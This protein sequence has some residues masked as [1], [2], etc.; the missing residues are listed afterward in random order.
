MAAQA[1]DLADA[2]GED[3]RQLVVFALG[4]ERLALPMSAVREIV[5]PL[6]LVPVPRAPELLLGL[7]NLR[8][9][10]LPVLDL[11][12]LVGAAPR[13]P[14]EATRVLVLEWRGSRLGLVV[15]AVH[16]VLE[17]A[18]DALETARGAAAALATG[19]LAGVV[20]DGAEVVQVLDLDAL[21]D[22]R[23]EAVAAGA[24]E[25][26]VLEAA[27]GAE[28][29]ADGGG[30]SG[31]DDGSEQLVAFRVGG[32]E[33]ALRIGEVREIVRLP[34]RVEAVPGAGP[35]A[36]G[37]MPLRG[38]TLPLVSLAALLGIEAAP[39]AAGARV[40]VTALP[41]GGRR[42]AVGLV[43]DAVRE[44]LRVPE[45]AREAVPA[46]LARGGGLGEIGELCRLE[47]GRR[48][49][50][51][52]EAG[53]L[54]ALEALGEVAEANA[55]EA[56]MDPESMHAETEGDAEDEVQLVVFQ[57]DGEEYG[58]PVEAV[59]EITRVPERLSRVP[60]TPEWVEGLVNLRGSALPVLDMR[61]RFGLPRAARSERQRIL[62]LDL[63]GTRTGFVTDSV[64]EVLSVPRAL[65]EAAPRLSE[66]QARLMGRVVNLAEGGRM[67]VVLDPEALV[68]ED[69]REALAESARSAA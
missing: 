44:V 16:R 36:L 64:T 6:P 28:T 2:P 52:L 34:E 33:L 17:A 22:G 20:R 57:L 19:V 56:D 30:A 14:D 12:R 62:V 11:R 51:V 10:V 32:Q 53:R 26:P 15:D 66:E 67:I 31:E 4:E 29:G 39:P 37:L 27:E 55:E 45:A 9:R 61:A 47:G 25:G 8:G 43:V 3:G 7:A 46:L 38:R 49:V 48:L 1:P 68:D 5:R 18:A 60:R 23:L 50:A 63:A 13:E 65:V 58:L 54:G 24:G 40:L 69:E 41:V 59:R 35:H 21:L 42:L